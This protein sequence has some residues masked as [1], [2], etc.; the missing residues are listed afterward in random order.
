MEKEK[1]EETLFPPKPA[2]TKDGEWN[3]DF[4]WQDEDDRR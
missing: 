3:D 2:I 4:D 1:Q